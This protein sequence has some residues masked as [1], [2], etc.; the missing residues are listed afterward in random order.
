MKKIP[1]K[2]GKCESIKPASPAQESHKIGVPAPHVAS[3]LTVLEESD[4]SLHSKNQLTSA[5]L[6]FWHR[7]LHAETESRNR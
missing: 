5:M 7:K 6:V 3:L 4:H 1:P 2:K